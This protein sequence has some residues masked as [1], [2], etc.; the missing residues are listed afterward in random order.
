MWLVGVDFYWEILYICRVKVF[1][2]EMGVRWSSGARYSRGSR[3]SR[4]SRYSRYSSSS[5]GFRYF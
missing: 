4:Y 2:G 1:W 5:R 3:G